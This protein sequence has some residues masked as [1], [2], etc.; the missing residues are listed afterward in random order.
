MGVP[1]LF[2]GFADLWRLGCLDRA[3]GEVVLAGGDL[4]PDVDVDGGGGGGEPALAVSEFRSLRARDGR[5]PPG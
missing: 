2:P 1:P 4:A 5:Q 3:R